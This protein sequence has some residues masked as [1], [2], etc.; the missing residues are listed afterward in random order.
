MSKYYLAFYK[1]KTS[2]NYGWFRN[3]TFRLYNRMTKFFT[4]G[5]YSHVELVIKEDTEEYF[6]C[7][8]SSYMDKGVRVKKMLLPTDKW[9]LVEIH[10]IDK[11][12]IEKFYQQTKDK[13]YDLIGAIGVVAGLREHPNKYFC[14]EWCFD[15]LFNSDQG[16]RFSPN[17]LYSIIVGKNNYDSKNGKV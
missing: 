3:L 1:G 14:S 8:S 5:K 9:D 10:N 15:C 4:K 13:D 17:H 12:K 2:S 11:A 16:W 7:Y 6:T